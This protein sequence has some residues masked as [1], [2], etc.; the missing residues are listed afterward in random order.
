MIAL[1]FPESQKFEKV[2][3]PHDSCTYDGSTAIDAVTIL[4]LYQTGQITAK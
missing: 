1:L 2:T 4:T 3:G